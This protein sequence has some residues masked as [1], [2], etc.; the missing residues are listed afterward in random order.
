VVGAANSAADAALDL[1]RGGARVTLVHRRT[2]PSKHLKY[3]VGPDLA[4]R[5]KAGE[6][7]GRFETEIVEIRRDAVVVRHVPT[8][9]VDTVPN[10]FVFALTGYR[11]DAAFLRS[12]GIALDPRTE[13]PALDAETLESNVPGLY[14]A[15]VAIAGLENHNVFIENGRFHGKQVVRAL[16]VA[17]PPSGKPVLAPVT[18]P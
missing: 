6:I 5:I 10:D 8:G 3:W 7:R 13:K 14:V 16:Q 18:A 11:A 17:L 2:E 15:G 1:F 4:N 12:M 9:A